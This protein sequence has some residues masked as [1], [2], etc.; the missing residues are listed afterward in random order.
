MKNFIQRTLA[1]E[2]ATILIIFIFFWINISSTRFVIQN[3]TVIIINKL[4]THLNTHLLYMYFE[5]EKRGSG[6]L[7]KTPFFYYTYFE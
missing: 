4:N 5:K 3:H 2:V 7:T 6:L 1:T